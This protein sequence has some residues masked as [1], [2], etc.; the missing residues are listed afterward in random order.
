MSSSTWSLTPIEV[1]S[2]PPSPAPFVDS[3]FEAYDVDAIVSPTKRVQESRGQQKRCK[4]RRD[5]TLVVS[6]QYDPIDFVDIGLSVHSAEH[7]LPEP[8]FNAY[9]VAV[10][11]KRAGLFHLSAGLFIAQGWDSKSDCIKVS[12]SI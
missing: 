8:V 3:S 6:N 1:N 7:D 11:E 5:N 4:R 12:L 10:K 2:P 9:M